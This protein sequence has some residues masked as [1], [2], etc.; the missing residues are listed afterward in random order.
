MAE[1][2]ADVFS[3]SKELIITKK[4]LDDIGKSAENTSKVIDVDFKEISK[5]VT[6]L[7]EKL[8]K[9]TGPLLSMLFF[10]MGIQNVFTSAFKSIFEGFTK[11]TGVG[12]A[13]N[14]LTTRLSA[15][16][17]YFKFQLGEALA[18]NTLFTGFI[19]FLIDVIQYLQKMPDWLKTTIGFIIIAGIAFGFILT[20]VGQIGLGL[21]GLTT[22]AEWFG[23]T[24]LAAFGGILLTVLAVLAI[25]ALIGLAF[26]INSDHL[27]DLGL[28]VEGFWNNVL[29]IIVTFLAGLVN[30]IILAITGIVGVF[31]I[32]GAVI[33]GVMDVA[34]TAIWESVKS[35]ATGI[36]DAFFAALNGESIADAFVKGFTSVNIADKIAESFDRSVQRG[37][38]ALLGLGDVSKKITGGVNELE[39][40]SQT[41]LSTTPDKDTSNTTVNNFYTLDEALA[42][43]IITQEEYITARNNGYS[44]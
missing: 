19:D 10:G 16:W 13:F 28:E 41:W 24:S 11:A 17:A 7:N 1:I 21:V 42:T 5:T 25:I 15:N 20:M 31:V 26:K 23:I 44:G 38:E 3:N 36:K 6:S 29:S 2:R 22:L 4:R 12:G 34:F 30:L 40:E 8:Q 9:L 33:V 32:V 37:E 35:I 14:Q 18:N 39:L 43:G 27:N